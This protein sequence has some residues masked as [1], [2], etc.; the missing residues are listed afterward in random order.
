MSQGE[1][2]VS[3]ADDFEDHGSFMRDADMVK[4]TFM[5]KSVLFFNEILA[6]FPGRSRLLGLVGFQE[7][8]F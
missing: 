5:P 7:S 8:R 4:P 3:M 2:D 6:L 1:M